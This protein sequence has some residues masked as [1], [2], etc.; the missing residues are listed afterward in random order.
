MIL[1]YIIVLTCIW[2]VVF[3]IALP[4]GSQVTIKPE[5][6]HAD[7]A[8]TKP[9]LGLKFII[10]SIIS[11]ILTILVVHLIENHHISNFIDKYINWLSG[12]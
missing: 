2:W 3:Y 1:S 12:Y 9:R 4:F 11:I 7:S 8:P 6:G 5:K 10:T